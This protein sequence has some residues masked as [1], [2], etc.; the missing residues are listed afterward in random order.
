M[1]KVAIVTTSGL[2][3]TANGILWGVNITKVG[4][5]ASTVDVYDNTSAAG[6]KVFSG[7]GLAQ[8]SF[9]QND[10]NGGGI[11]VSNGI[12]VNLAGTT[13]ATVNVIYD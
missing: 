7:D 13:N 4:T 1:A 5:G 6:T 2:V 8:G 12:F 9:Q 10:G 3:K 11:P